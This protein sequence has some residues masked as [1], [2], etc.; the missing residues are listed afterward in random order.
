MSN[1]INVN[2]RLPDDDGRYLACCGSV[3]IAYYT[4]SNKKWK[5]E[6][7]TSG[8]EQQVTHWMMLPEPPKK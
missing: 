7:S 5:R 6:Y 1:W 8:L 2:E 4:K 3:F